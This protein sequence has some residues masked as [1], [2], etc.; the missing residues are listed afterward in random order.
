MD[1]SA[2]FVFISFG[3]AFADIRRYDKLSLITQN[4]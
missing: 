2:S 4:N 3:M 1:F